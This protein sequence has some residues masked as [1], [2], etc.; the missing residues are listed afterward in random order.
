LPIEIINFNYRL[1][2]LIL[3]LKKAQILMAYKNIYLLILFI[4]ISCASKKNTVAE[5]TT[6]EAHPKLIFL[7]YTLTKDNKDGKRISLI[8]KIITEGKLKTIPNTYP[9]TGAVHD[10]ICMQ[11]DKHSNEIT[12]ITIENPLSKIIEYI[13]DSLRFENRKVELK[14]AQFSLRLQLNSKT[15]FILISEIIDTLQQTNPIIKTK[16]D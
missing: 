9:K 3:Y 13:N 14:N 16:L 4:F 12:H 1:L 6:Q 7:N 2:N 11:L 15:K 8:N 10:L 5:T